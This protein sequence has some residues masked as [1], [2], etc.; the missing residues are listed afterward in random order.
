M[1]K[2]GQYQPFPQPPI[3]GNP[4]TYTSTFLL[5]QMIESTYNY[6]LHIRS[7]YLPKFCLETQGY[8]F[9]SNSIYYE[10]LFGHKSRSTETHKKLYN[11]LALLTHPDK[12]TL[13]NANQ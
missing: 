12:C 5:D 13:P 7:E 11:Q 1:F 10:I 8:V 3:S 9:N 4:P 6:M 2:W